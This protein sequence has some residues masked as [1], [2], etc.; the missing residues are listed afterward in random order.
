MLY[1]SFRKLKISKIYEILLILIFSSAC[2][3]T[4]PRVDDDVS[5]WEQNF[6]SSVFSFLP[7][8]TYLD[9]FLLRFRPKYF[10]PST[11]NFL[12][13]Y[14]FCCF[15]RF[16]LLLMLLKAFSNFN[17]A[18]RE[19]FSRSL[20]VCENWITDCF[21]LVLISSVRDNVLQFLH[22]LCR[23]I[24]VNRK[25]WDHNKSQTVCLGVHYAIF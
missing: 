7:V 6:A 3:Y 2:A 22:T 17:L 10:F 8:Y 11:H 15:S 19:F 1:F 13:F 24:K 4:K 12:F 18:V 16:F 20:N 25:W 23:L 5:L 9:G 14:R 21:G